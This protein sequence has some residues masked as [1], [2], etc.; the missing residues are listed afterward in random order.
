LRD[1]NPITQAVIL[2]DGEHRSGI[3]F[4]WDFQ[5]LPPPPTPTP[6]PAFTPTWTPTLLPASFFKVLV[7][8]DHIYYRGTNCGDKEAQ[9]QVQV[10]DPAKVAGVWLFVRLKG[11]ESG[12]T[13]SWGEALVMTGGGS[14]WYSYLL[15]AEDIPDFAK[16]R[17]AWVQYQFV[18]YDKSFARVETSG[19]FSDVELSACGK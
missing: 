17:E 14:G 4:G 9:F 18:A 2:G 7:K 8:P 10:A 19:V 5:F 15:A 16:F 11:K 13:T 6:T 1:V 3:I 12:E